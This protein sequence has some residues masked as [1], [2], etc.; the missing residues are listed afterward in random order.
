MQWLGKI[1]QFTD[2]VLGA[3]GFDM[4]VAQ[5]HWIISRSI[6]TCYVPTSMQPYTYFTFMIRAS[7]EV[8]NNVKTW[9]LDHQQTSGGGGYFK[10]LVTL[11]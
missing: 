2:E 3:A 9:K 5:L 8:Q 6:A 7:A 1:T 4:Y 11:G 10:E